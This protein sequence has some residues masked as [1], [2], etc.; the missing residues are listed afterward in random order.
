MHIMSDFIMSACSLPQTKHFCWWVLSNIWVVLHFRKEDYSGYA[1]KLTTCDSKLLVSQK[2]LHFTEMVLL[3][4][5]N[6][7]SHGWRLCS[8]LH[9][10]YHLSHSSG[11]TTAVFKETLICK[12]TKSEQRD[13]AAVL[14]VC[15]PSP[16]M[17]LKGMV[18]FMCNLQK[19]PGAVHSFQNQAQKNI[20]FFGI[21]Y[22]RSWY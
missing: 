14:M 18:G 3:R 11:T 4:F 21:K 5:H 2:A 7:T 6:W 12:S 22:Q 13:W 10:L 16:Q 8:Y 1:H 19:L 9:L 20:L 17:A 15:E